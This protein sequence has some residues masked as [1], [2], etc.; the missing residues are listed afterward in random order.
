M[1]DERTERGPADRR[2]RWIVVL[3]MVVVGL[4]AASFLPVP[5]AVVSGLR[6]ASG[7][8]TF[9]ALVLALRR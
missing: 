7:V 2:Q 4:I 5:D 6:L 1:T 9:V 8:V 3:L